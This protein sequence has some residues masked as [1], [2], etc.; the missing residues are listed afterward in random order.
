VGS[1]GRS[2]EELAR[3]VREACEE[4]LGSGSVIADHGDG[5]SDDREPDSRFQ[6]GAFTTEA[7]ARKLL[8]RLSETG[9]YAEMWINMIP[10]HQTVEG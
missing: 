2:N 1:W 5:S 9:T 3:V 4:Q 10:V 7:E 6:A 8:D